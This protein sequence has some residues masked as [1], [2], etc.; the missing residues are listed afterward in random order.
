M[1]DNFIKAIRSEKLDWLQEKYP[2]AV[3]LLFYIARHARR[4]NGHIDGLIIGDSIIGDH[5]KM[6]MSRQNYRTALE[7][8]IELKIVKIIWNGKSFLEREK[9]TIKVTIK[10]MLVNLIDSTI[11]DINPNEGNQHANQQLTNSQPTANHKQE[12]KKE[13]ELSCLKE[14]SKE[15]P[16]SVV[17]PLF[18]SDMQ[19]KEVDAFEGYLSLFRISID[20]ATLLRW[21][22][23]YGSEKLSKTISLI[24]DKINSIQ[25]HGGWIETALQKN[26]VEKEENIQKN[27]EFAI[28]FIQANNI[29]NLKINKKYC[30]DKNG[31]DYQYSIDNELFKKILTEKFKNII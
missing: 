6:G 2:Y 24:K 25:N 28:S 11:F 27:K 4:Y 12:T 9:S 10:S 26:Y 31:N 21:I 23:K 7:K 15:K 5:K 16:K 20:R 1:S 13:Q 17:V 30:I 19:K 3:L 18:L 29:S 22:N 14:T 8:L